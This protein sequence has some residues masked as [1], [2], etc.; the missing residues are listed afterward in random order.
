MAHVLVI[1]SSEPLRKLESTVRARMARDDGQL[2]V[3][4]KRGGNRNHRRLKARLENGP[5]AD[6]T[7]YLLRMPAMDRSGAMFAVS[8]TPFPVAD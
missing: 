8:A 5:V 7:M 6:G 1:K 4:A 2:W 3:I